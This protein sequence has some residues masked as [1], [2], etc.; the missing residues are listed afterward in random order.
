[1]F[2][3]RNSRKTNNTV[4][5]TDLLNAKLLRKGL[6]KLYKDVGTP[7]LHQFPCD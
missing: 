3:R 2:G 4:L 5:N 1:V 7:V 6:E